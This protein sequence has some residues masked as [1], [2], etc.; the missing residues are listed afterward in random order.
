MTDEKRDVRLEPEGIELWLNQV[1]Q[2]V[3]EIYD[4]K[5][6]WTVKRISEL[7]RQCAEHGFMIGYEAAKLERE[8]EE[9][10]DYRRNRQRIL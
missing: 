6:L 8:E 9:K 3:R 5:G 7:A 1:Q 10:N 4:T 2:N